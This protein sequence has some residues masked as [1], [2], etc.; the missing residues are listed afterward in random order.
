V[1]FFLAKYIVHNLLNVI[2]LA[3]VQGLTEF[4]PVSSSGHLVIAQRLLGV[5]EPGITLE[6]WLHIGTLVSILVFYRRVIV[7]LIKG[8]FRLERE[9]LL[10]G[11]IILISMIPAV[12][13][14]LLCHQFVESFYESPRVTGSLMIFTGMILIGMRWIPNRD[15]CLTV[16]RAI[17]IGL[18][19]ALALFAG[20]SRSG[21]T[22]SAARASGV[23]SVKAAEF[24][25]L[26]VIPLLV[27]AAFMDFMKLP[28][29]GGGSCPG[30]LA[31]GVAVSGVIGYLA[32]TLL[33]KVLKGGRFWMFGIY[34]VLVG[35]LA[36]TLL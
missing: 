27:G 13:F 18:A 4:L 24:S 22:I 5:G 3:L 26:M 10:M 32:L 1:T 7:D 16:P 33:V 2:F 25:F 15:G 29:A 12:V 23:S 19:Q 6:V 34:C 36:A 9:S 28:A 20:I 17:V 30:L 14:Y 8:V 35:A 11:A 21:M 31:V